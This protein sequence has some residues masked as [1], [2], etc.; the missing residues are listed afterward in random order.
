ME[1]RDCSGLTWKVDKT[2]VIFVKEKKKWTKVGVPKLDS[3]TP[4]KDQAKGI[5]FMKMEIDRKLYLLEEQLLDVAGS[6]EYL[7]PILMDLPKNNQQRAGITIQYV[8]CLGKI[9]YFLKM[10]T[11]T[12]PTTKKKGE[13]ALAFQIHPIAV[14][15]LS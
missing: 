2:K 8:N 10:T 15:C 12:T 11:D 5:F 13:A 7:A 1:T 4:Y 3:I 9:M 14:L 6:S